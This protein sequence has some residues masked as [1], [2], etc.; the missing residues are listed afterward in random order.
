MLLVI[1]HEPV[2]L[3]ICALPFR[4]GFFIINDFVKHQKAL[5]P[6]FITIIAKNTSSVFFC[7]SLYST[8]SIKLHPQ[9]KLLF[10][11]K[12]NKLKR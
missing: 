3:Q 6:F 12:A 7:T 2:E 10:V 5:K 11:V 4:K 1:S 9:I 8:F